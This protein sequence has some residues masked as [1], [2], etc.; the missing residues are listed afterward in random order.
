MNSIL[1]QV[2]QKSLETIKLIDS[3]PRIKELDHQIATCKQWLEDNS[4]KELSR[5]MRIL[6]SELNTL[7]EIV[8]AVKNKKERF[9]STYLWRLN[10]DP[11]EYNDTSGSLL[12]I[13]NRWSILGVL[14]NFPEFQSDI[15]INEGPSLGNH[16]KLNGD[17]SIS[18]TVVKKIEEIPEDL[19]VNAKN[20]K[21][22]E[23]KLSIVQLEFNNLETLAKRLALVDNEFEKL[24]NSSEYKLIE[25]TQNQLTEFKD[26]RQKIADEIRSSDL[27]KTY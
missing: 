14:K 18:I 24:I 4:S 23:S 25:H 20:F 9:E 11:G 19:K 17:G 2:L 1:D 16:I 21:Y 3:D 12:E 7:T 15:S 22:S 10:G 6:R 8:D 13:C 27:V 5:K 26:Q